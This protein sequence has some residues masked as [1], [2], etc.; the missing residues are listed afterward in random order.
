[1]M[2]G[3]LLPVGKIPY[4]P[5][6]RVNETLVFKHYNAEEEVLGKKMKDWLRFSVC[7]WHTFRGTGMDPFGSGTLQRPWD[8]GSQSLENAKRR[9]KVAFEFMQKLGIEFYTFHDVD[10]APEGNNLKE[11]GR[12]LDEVTDYMLELQKVTNIKPLWATCNLFS[13]VRYMNGASTNPDVHVFAQAAAQVKKG[14]DLALKLGAQGFVFWGGREGYQTPL[15]TDVHRELSNMAKFFKMA[16]DYKQKIGF[17]G[18][19]YIEPKPKEPSRH[20][21][22]YGCHHFHHH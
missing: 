14:L 17:Q 20:Q 13:N 8:D 3:D 16:V 9:V 11:F 2:E 7:F 1:M 15:N 5:D 21:Y 22:D 4:K 19:F 12:N 18:Q 10:I 6:C